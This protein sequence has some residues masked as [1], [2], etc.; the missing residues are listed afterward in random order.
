MSPRFAAKSPKAPR[1]AEPGNSSAKS[2]KETKLTYRSGG[3]AVS[4]VPE[5]RRFAIGILDAASATEI[6]ETLGNLGRVDFSAKHGLALVECA[7]GTDPRI[8]RE[9]VE[10]LVEEGRLDFSAPVLRDPATGLAQILNDE[11]TVRFSPKLALAQV[12]KLSAKHGL[13]IA[14]RN[15]F[16]PNQFV[17]KLDKPRG[18][19]ALATATKL[20][21][22]AMV[23]FAVPNFVS[24]F[25]KS[26]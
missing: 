25:R 18:L 26:A 8:L 16:V 14:R 19:E 21:R 9:R 6:A 24:E 20:D 11:I 13:T 4:I 12:R 10:Q 23:D 5:E 15:E 7:P 22:E 1:T 2:V 3:K 17:L